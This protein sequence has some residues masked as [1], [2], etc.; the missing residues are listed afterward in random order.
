MQVPSTPIPV[1]FKSS[2]KMDKELSKQ[3]KTV[4]GSSRM[5]ELPP[6]TLVVWG[7]RRNKI[8]R[9]V[10]DNSYQYACIEEVSSPQYDIHYM[11][12]SVR[13]D[14]SLN[15]FIDSINILKPFLKH[16]YRT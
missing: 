8:Y 10:G 3:L 4:P 11:S 13:G 16:L 2:R 6:N 5:Y 14:H 7:D 12:G 15:E 1:V 9:L